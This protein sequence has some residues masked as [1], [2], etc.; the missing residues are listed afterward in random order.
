MTLEIN[1]LQLSTCLEANSHSHTLWLTKHSASQ[2]RRILR[3]IALR[4]MGHSLM[5]SPQSWQVP[6]PQRKIMFFSRSRHTGHIVC[7]LM[8]CSC[9]CNFC[10]SALTLVLSL[11]FCNTGIFPLASSS[12][13]SSAPFPPQH[14]MKGALRSTT[15]RHCTHF[16]IRLAQFSQAHM[17]P[18]G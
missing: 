8:S 14:R 1:S 13:V 2:Y 18:Q 7:S 10:T 3:S 12:P 15:A 4:Q 16:F 9:C 5:R 6:W 17:C 11:S